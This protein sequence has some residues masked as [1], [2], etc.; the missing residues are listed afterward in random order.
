MESS[1]RTFA[2]IQSEVEIFVD[3]VEECDQDLIDFVDKLFWK[4][5]LL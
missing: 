5:C 1:R 2:E 3:D 4:V